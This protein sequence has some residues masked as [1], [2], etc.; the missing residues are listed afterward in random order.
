M[1]ENKDLLNFVN[2]VSGDAFLKVEENLGDGY[3]RLKVSEAE[4][5][6]AKHDIRHVEDVVVELLRNARDAHAQRIFLATTREG[7]ERSLTIVD[8]GVGVPTEMM[9]LIFEPRVTSKLETMVMDRWGVHG[10]GM[11]LFSIRSNAQ[12]ARI[13]CSGAHKGA[14]LA[15]VT[16]AEHL[17]EKTDQSTWPTVERDEGGVLKVARGPHNIVR[18]TVEFALEHVGIDVFIGSP[19][20]V[21]ATLVLL[22]RFELDESDLLFCENISRLPVWQRPGAAADA[23][24]LADTA[25]EMGLAVSERTAHRILAGEIAPLRSVMSSVV[26]AAEGAPVPVAPDIYRDRR[27]LKIHHSDLARF[28]SELEKAFDTVAERYYLHLKCEPKITV[29]KDDIRVRF[30]VDKED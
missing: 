26:G 10:R 19:S 16:D 27:G 25:S 30:E 1:P 7:S 12:E 28:R 8:D 17:P 15:V 4:R 6:Q 23:G 13:A 18:R 11:A 2:A 21:L 20:E 29:G 9:E 22:A 3:V 24:E 14:A 5:R